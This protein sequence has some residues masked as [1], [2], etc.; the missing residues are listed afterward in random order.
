MAQT[1]AYS[2]SGG[3]EPVLIGCD[4]TSTFATIIRE[5]FDQ[6]SGQHPG[7]EKK[8]T[9]K[10][11]SF[12]R[13]GLG[14]EGKWTLEE[15]RPTD[16]NS[17]NEAVRLVRFIAESLG[18][19]LVVVV[20]EFDLIA[21]A[22][23]QRVFTN[24]L[25]QVSDQHVDAVIIVCGIGDSVEALMDAHGSADRYFHT[26]G[27]KQLPWEAR[28]EIAEIAAA[29]LGINIDRDTVIRIA[30]IS[31][32]FPHYVLFICEKLFWRVYEARNDGNVT[33]ALFGSAMHDAA[34]AMDMKLRKPY[35]DATQKY[36][37]D[38][39]T[40]LLAVPDGHELRR[41]SS[42]YLNPMNAS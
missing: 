37:D 31:G 38:Y 40:V 10:G 41:R 22:S 35:E 13:F 9:E 23:E 18:I 17:V 25:K 7:F 14:G 26:V 8:I 32:G 34:A 5:V 29:T 1:C 15:G 6:I 42:D 24:F 21:L 2:L 33:P 20:D 39:E 27:L 11:L 16:P 3:A 36:R 4:E 12:S 30:R 28:F 19:R